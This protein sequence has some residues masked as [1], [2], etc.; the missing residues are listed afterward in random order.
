MP[1]GPASEL[2]EYGE[3]EIQAFAL[4]YA[5]ELAEVHPDGSVLLEDVARARSLHWRSP[6]T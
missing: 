6:S 5:S 1:S 2:I 3:D 4:R